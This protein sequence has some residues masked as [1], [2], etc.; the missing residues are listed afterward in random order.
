MNYAGMPFFKV[1]LQEV[2]FLWREKRA[3]WGVEYY[4][5]IPEGRYRVRGGRLA[6]VRPELP[7]DNAVIPEGSYLKEIIGESLASFEARVK[8]MASAAPR[9]PSHRGG[10]GARPLER[11]P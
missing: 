9:W 5:T 8:A 7:V 11:R 1:G 4:S 2:V 6:S 10:A 3:D